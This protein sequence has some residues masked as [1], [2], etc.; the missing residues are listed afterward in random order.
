M[1]KP[2][3]L[4][5]DVRQTCIQLV[6]GY[7]RRVRDYYDRR[8][9]IIEGTP[10]Q[11]EV[12]KDRNNPDDWKKTTRFYAPSSHNASRT[13]ENKAMQ[14]QGI[15]DLLETKRMRAVEQ[16]KLQIGLDLPEDMRKR[17]VDA[18]MLNCKSGR[19]YPY[20]VLDVEGLSERGFYREREAF[21]LVIAVYL[22]LL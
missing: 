16:A 8:R 5:D 7:E 22:E 17:L 11:Y 20:K 4:P 19:R 3:R 10:C 21:L 12:I 14:L 1:S 15:E 9:K 6:R 2:K 13:S 18:I